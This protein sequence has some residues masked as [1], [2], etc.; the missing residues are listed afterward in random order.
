MFAICGLCFSRLSLRHPLL[1]CCL[2]PA[3][4]F[5][6]PRP[7]WPCVGTHPG[8]LS[9]VC[10][11]LSKSA[12]PGVGTSLGSALASPGS[13]LKPWRLQRRPQCLSSVLR[14]HHQE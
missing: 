6:Q 10:Q 11:A 2:P 14:P 7:P 1:A 12:S 4:H 13:P 8:R 9:W 5:P 3:Q